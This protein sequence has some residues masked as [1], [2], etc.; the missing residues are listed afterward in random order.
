MKTRALAFPHSFQNSTIGSLF[1]LFGLVCLTGCGP[2]SVGTTD[3]E[4]DVEEDAPADSVEGEVLNDVEDATSMETD[5]TVEDANL[6]DIA[7]V[8]DT[9]VHETS[10]LDA[11]DVDDN[12]ELD[13]P[14]FAWTDEHGDEQYCLCTQRRHGGT[15]RYC[16][17]RNVT[18]VCFLGMSH[19]GEIRS[20]WSP[21]GGECWWEGEPEP[22]SLFT[23]PCPW[24]D[25]PFS[26]D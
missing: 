11:T 6:V 1:L 20:S 7:N 17:A 8:P 24:V 13:C 9:D 4:P 16:C 26:N 10:E 22:D 14:D 5:V 2:S 15:D 18:Y 19:T 12:V 21:A 23:T 3:E 25:D